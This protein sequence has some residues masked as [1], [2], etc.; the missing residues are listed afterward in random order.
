MKKRARSWVL[1]PGLALCLLAFGCGRG[2]APASETASAPAGSRGVAGWEEIR[3]GTDAIFSGLHFVDAEVGW[4]V[5]GSPFISGGIVGRTEDGGRTWRYVTGAVTGGGPRTPLHSV[6]G[7]DRQ[8]ACAVGGR[9]IFLTIDGGA[10]WQPAR[11]DRR[12]VS[13]VSTLHFID[14][15]EG[16][17]AGRGGVLH[18]NDGGLNWVELGDGTATLGFEARAI[19]FAD[20]RNGWLAG[21]GGHLMR[22]R[23]GGQTWA[24]VLVP[25]PENGTGRTPFLWG[26][27]WAGTLDGWVVGEFGTIL[28]TADGGDSW[29][30]EDAGNREAFLTAVAFTDQ[31]NGW[32]T[33]FLPDKARSFVWHTADGGATWSVERRLEGEELRALQMLDAETGWTVGDRVRTEPQRM[34]RRARPP[35]R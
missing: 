1:A 10:S 9:E 13:S 29:V 34:L 11:S 5:G 25:R 2:G 14:D 20:A 21:E 17:A 31:R 28:R 32:V 12:A 16:W 35:A 33:G 18:T 19:H 7:L 6:Q 22:T 24:R 27:S 4:I 8:R 15:R 30:L 3:I 23:D 26:M